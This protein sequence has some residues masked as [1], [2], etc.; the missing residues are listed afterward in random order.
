MHRMNVVPGGRAQSQARKLPEALGELPGGE[1]TRRQAEGPT[2]S[3]S[4]F[5]KA[6]SKA[7]LALQALCRSGRGGQGAEETLPSVLESS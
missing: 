2:S 6:L 1:C 3:F 7:M 4:S 5:A